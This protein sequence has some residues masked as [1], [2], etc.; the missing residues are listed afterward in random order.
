MC[1]Y[2]LRRLGVALVAWGARA[3]SPVAALVSRA[4]NILG[5]ILCGKTKLVI[6]D[7]KDNKLRLYKSGTHDRSGTYDRLILGIVLKASIA[8]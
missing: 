8:H 7:I 5:E 4:Y 2:I 3:P 6:L 1:V